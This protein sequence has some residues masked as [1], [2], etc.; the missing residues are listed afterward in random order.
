MLAHRS[1][2]VTS[3]SW[4]GHWGDDA[5]Y[6]ARR[7]DGVC[8][9]ID[10]AVN[11]FDLAGTTPPPPHARPVE[12]LPAG[13]GYTLR[14]FVQRPLDTCHV[15]PSIDGPS[16]IHPRVTSARLLACGVRRRRVAQRT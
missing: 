14:V 8:F 6:Y 9:A 5:R 10:G 4:T 1:L 12:S 13:G 2:H 11:V 3:E 15:K 7:S 16:P